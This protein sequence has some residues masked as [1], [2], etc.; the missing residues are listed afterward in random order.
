[1][2]VGA[3][4]FFLGDFNELRRRLPA[5]LKNAQERGDLFA[6][7][8]VRPQLSCFLR[9]AADDPEGARREAREPLKRWSRQAFHNQH[10][11]SVQGE[12][13]VDMYAGE[14]LLAWDRLA[15]CWPEFQRSFLRV[16]RL[17]FLLA[18]NLRARTA[19]AAGTELQRCA[20]GRPGH[21]SRAR[22]LLHIAERAAETIE[23]RRVPWSDG[24]SLLLRAGIH[25][26]RGETQR[27]CPLL[28]AAESRLQ[29]CDMAF[30]TAA[31]RYRLGEL[32]RG[33]EGRSLIETADR[34]MAGQGIQNPTRILAVVT[35]GFL[36]PRG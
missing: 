9:L 34:W 3:S 6:Q 24:L 1:M 21:V 26:A 10:F 32:L 5:L 18:L 15:G 8:L 11:F 16:H 35:P 30:H 19:V 14:T 25:A 7:S 20:A 22:E 2:A 36:P 33:A 12:V 17:V 31:A 23:R 13:H 27:S 29:A 28:R 4:L